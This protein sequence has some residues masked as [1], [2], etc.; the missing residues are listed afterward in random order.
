MQFY[1]PIFGLFLIFVIWLA[2]ER[3]KATKTQ[4]KQTADFWE[5]ESAANNTRKKSLDDLSYITIPD[6]IFLDSVNESYNLC[7]DDQVLKNYLV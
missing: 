7:L 6:D 2:Y 5:R 3:A 1:Y 4:Q